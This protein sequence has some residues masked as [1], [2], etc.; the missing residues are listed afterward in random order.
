[1]DAHNGTAEC[2]REAVAVVLQD[3]VT[4]TV[5]AKSNPSNIYH[6]EVLPSHTSVDEYPALA[7]M[8]L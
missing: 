8:L 4:D 2:L 7:F 6:W 1:M 5:S 3:N